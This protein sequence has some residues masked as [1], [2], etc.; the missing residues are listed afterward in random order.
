MACIFKW[1]VE[2]EMVG[3]NKPCDGSHMGCVGRLEVTVEA[4]GLPP[5]LVVRSLWPD[6][7]MYLVWTF[8]VCWC[9][10]GP[11]TC[12]FH[13]SIYFWAKNAT[14]FSVDPLPRLFTFLFCQSATKLG[15]VHLGSGK[16][17]V[18]KF[19]CSG[20]EVREDRGRMW[21]WRLEKEI[22]NRHLL[23]VRNVNPVEMFCW[24]SENTVKIFFS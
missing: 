24:H 14:L 11:K 2:L 18:Y 4:H 22:R 8:S 20:I 17:H 12:A 13:L 1:E 23:S 6:I 7:T 9:L 16:L 21:H 15:S 5:F 3:R 10:S 19:Q